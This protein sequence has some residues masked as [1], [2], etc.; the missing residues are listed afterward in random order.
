[1]PQGSFLGPLFFIIFINS[2]NFV[3]LNKAI[4]P[5]KIAMYADE[6]TQSVCGKNV[7]AISTK[8][9]SDIHYYYVLVKKKKKE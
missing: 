3:Q 4:S 9:T 2:M 7:E 8:L 5:V 6:T 1:M